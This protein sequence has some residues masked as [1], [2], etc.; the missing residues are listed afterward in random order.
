LNIELGKR[1]DML[2][3]TD[4]LT[5]PQV[6]F[7]DKHI[8]GAD[9]TISFLESWDTD[10]R[11]SSPKERYE[12]EI[13]SKSDS[14]DTRLKIPTEPPEVKPEPPPR[15]PH[16]GEHEFS[17]PN[18]DT[19]SYSKLYYTLTKILPNESKPYRGQSY[20]HS[21]TGS[22][23]VNAVMEHYSTSKDSAIR[24]LKN[25]QQSK[26]FD[27]VTK[28]HEIGDNEY[29]FKLQE[30]FQPRILNSIRVW[31][32]RVD[33][34]PNSL[35]IRLKKLLEKIESAATD[36]NGNVDYLQAKED[37]NYYTFQEATCELQKID[38]F[39]MDQSTRLSFSIN[40]YNLMIKHAFIQLGI[41]ASNLQ[42]AS[43]FGKVGYNVGGHKLAFNELENGVI[44]A[45]KRT[46][47]TYLKPFSN[48][49]P[50]LPLALKVLDPR[51]HF[52]LNCGAK[53]CPPIKSF[54][55]RSIDEEL[56][57][58]SLAFHESNE[59]T[60]VDEANHELKVSKI[61]YW[62]QSD[63]TPSTS[64]LPSAIL[65]FL[66]GEKKEKLK[67]M[68]T[69]SKPIKVKFFDYDWTTNASKMRTFT[70]RELDSTKISVS[71]LSKIKV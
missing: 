26:M 9:D 62:Y 29:F 55:P 27:H 13:Q 42:R 15:S 40:I 47:Y 21:F 67:R 3:L 45:N 6:F 28:Q 46:P 69:S 1:S 23:A 50:R 10:N 59:N 61:L 22:E 5:V 30:Y 57:I 56:R 17:L 14:T 18:S 7:H 31:T 4:R 70:G 34:D 8:G 36:E 60:L 12:K 19:Q 49:D 71:A 33:P 66:R 2:A 16:Q 52:A 64:S 51:I 41:P 58:V 38:M 37:E 54:S 20:K 43:F 32:D 68:I 24:F 25:I 44:R 39:K 53:S 35:A 63:F 65:N 11:Y 48:S